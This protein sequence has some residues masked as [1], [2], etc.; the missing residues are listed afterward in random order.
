MTPKETWTAQCDA[1]LGILEDIGIE[2]ALGYLIGEKFLNF[3]EAAEHDPQW[4]AEIPDFVTEI[5]SIFEPWQ[6]AGYLDTPRRLGALGH[7]ADEDSHL[8][9]RSQVDDSDNLR[10]D[11]RNLLLLEAAKELL[12]ESDDEE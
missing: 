8:A 11:A 4:R 10:E 3:I 7:I 5:K 1:A 6:L 12:L 2:K 9:F